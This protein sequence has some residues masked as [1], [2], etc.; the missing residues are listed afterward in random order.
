MAISRKALGEG[1]HALTHTRTHWKALILPV[2][3]FV[4]AVGGGS[5]GVI[6]V[7]ESEYATYFRSGIAGLVL[8]IVLIW[9]VWPFLSWYAESYMVTDQRLITRQGVITRTG[10]DIPLGRIN[11]VSHERDLLDRILGCGTLVIWSAGEQGRIELYDIPHVEN[12]QR[13]I[14]EQLFHRDGVNDPPAERS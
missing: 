4:I 6:F 13:L 12:V 3:V 2:L 1:E 5:A 8:L 10:R 9:T 7:P 11:D 14:S